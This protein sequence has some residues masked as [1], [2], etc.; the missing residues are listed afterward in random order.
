MGVLKLPFI[1]GQAG[2]FCISWD[3]NENSG[4]F[5]S[6]PISDK[7]IVIILKLNFFK[8]GFG[9]IL[10]SKAKELIVEALVEFHKTSHVFGCFPE[11]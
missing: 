6:R 4:F 3:N 7:F 11:Y 10:I 8:S 1:R 5:A 2:H 9:F